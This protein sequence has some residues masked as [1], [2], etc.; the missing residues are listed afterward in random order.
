MG[1]WSEVHSRF[2]RGVGSRRGSGVFGA[3]R[4]RECGS[5]R[6]EGSI[7]ALSSQSESRRARA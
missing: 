7:F 5:E 1:G 6:S 3:R 4:R 2:D